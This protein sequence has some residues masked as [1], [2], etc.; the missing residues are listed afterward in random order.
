VAQSR[1]AKLLAAGEGVERDVETAA[2]YRALARRQGLTDGQLDGLLAKAP[3]D[4]VAKAEE[5]ARFWPL[6]P[7]TRVAEAET[8][9]NPAPV[10]VPAAPDPAAP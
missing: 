3:A 8:P 2:M 5:R 6:P 9:A 7:P 1:Y 10:E 4:V